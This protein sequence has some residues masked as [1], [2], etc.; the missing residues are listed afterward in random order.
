MY[1]FYNKPPKTRIDLHEYLTSWLKKL[2]P[3][4]K[5]TSI[6]EVNGE[7]FIQELGFRRAFYMHCVFR[8][9]NTNEY[10]WWIFGDD[11]ESYLDT[12]PTIRFPTYDSMLEQTIN[13]YYKLWGLVD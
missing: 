7:K 11:D 10:V 2:T 9:M 1:D 3:E 5:E 4:E 6:V 13:D 8:N 12:F